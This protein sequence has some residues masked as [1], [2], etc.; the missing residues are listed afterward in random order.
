[1]NDRLGDVRDRAR[2]AGWAAAVVV[3]ETQVVLGLL[4]AEELALDPDTPVGQVM[5]HGPST[6]RPYVPIKEMADYMVEHKL[7]SSPVTTSDGRLV[8]LLMRSDAVECAASATPC[9]RRLIRD[10]IAET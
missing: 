1:M 9:R 4:R 8:G 2:V 6:F 10:P 5:R 3:D 7:E